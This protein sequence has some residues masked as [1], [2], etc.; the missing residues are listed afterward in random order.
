MHHHPQQGGRGTA[1]GDHGGGHARRFRQHGQRP[2]YYLRW[3]RG[4]SFVPVDEEKSEAGRS[5]GRELPF[6]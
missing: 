1:G 2:L 3:W 5:I 6:D 4:F